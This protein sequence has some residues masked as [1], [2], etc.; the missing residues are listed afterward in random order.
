LPEAG[1][2]V[3]QFYGVEAISRPTVFDLFLDSP[4]N[5]VDLD[6]LVNTPGLFVIHHNGEFHPFAGIVT[7]AR[8]CLTHSIYRLVLSSPLTMLTYTRRQRVFLEKRIPEIIA[9]ILDESEISDYDLS[10][11]NDYPEKE[12]VVQYDESDFD[13]IN[14]LM[15][16]AGIWYFTKNYPLI[17][18]ELAG[19]GIGHAIVITDDPSNFETLPADPEVIFRGRN[20]L[21]QKENAS[22]IDHIYELELN[23]NIIPKRVTV[24]TQRG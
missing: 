21:V 14:R 2:S 16:K 8:Y 9:S 13:F 24:K 3:R 1:F 19:S 22:A 18:E 23:E 7:E 10:M 4:K 17:A 20:G 12:Y 15:E 11:T 5:D 6:R